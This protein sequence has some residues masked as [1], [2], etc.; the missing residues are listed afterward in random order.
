MANDD[1]PRQTADMPARR[2][3]P[4][5][6]LALLVLTGL[7]AGGLVLEVVFRNLFPQP[8]I[9]LYRYVDEFVFNRPNFND[10]FAMNPAA[11]TEHIRG[12]LPEFLR[13]RNRKEGPYYRA[14][15]ETNAVG[16]RD[17]RVPTY[18][19]PAEGRRVLVLGDSISFG[20]PEPLSQ[21]FVKQLEALLPGVETVNCSVI[22]ADT[23]QL[24]LFHRKECGK[25]EA[26]LVLLQF[27]VDKGA[28]EADYMG[29]DPYGPHFRVLRAL[30]TRLGTERTLRYVSWDAQGTPYLA[31]QVFRS[32]DLVGMLRDF[33]SPRMP[34]YER[35]HVVRFFEN[36]WWARP[37]LVRYLP[38]AFETAL[39]AGPEPMLLAD[40]VEVAVAPTPTPTPTVWFLKEIHRAVQA[41]GQKLLVVFIPTSY[42]ARELGLKRR[43]DVEQVQRYL[44]DAG[45]EI[46][47]MQRVFLE[48]EPP[49]DL[50]LLYYKDDYH[51]TAAGYRFIAEAVAPA[52]AR[53][54]ETDAP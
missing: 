34:L 10:I 43:L 13:G 24:Y 4:L 3:P 29:R 48:A 44:S 51:P 20:F 40:E 53:A 7:L 11:S 45:I 21:S 17:D 30:R 2:R 25:Y 1:E 28:A 26:D 37:Q 19:A 23:A 8:N 12:L 31:A 9:Y 42:R 41:R 39:R 27:T 5:F 35:S 38:E 36:G 16:Q 49:V 32:A 54:L 6:V 46:V 14:F 22:A 33:F 50:D 47:D 15:I 18:D 52:V